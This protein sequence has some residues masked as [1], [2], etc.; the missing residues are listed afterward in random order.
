VTDGPVLTT[1]RLILRL[2]SPE[3]LDG[4]AEFAADAE[5]T[6]HLGGVKTRSEAWRYLCEMRGAWEIRG[7]AMFSVIERSTGRWAGR[8]GPWEPEGWPGTEVGWGVHPDFAGKGYAYEGAV[9]A[10]D[11]VV[12]VLGWSDICHTIAPD[13]IRS[14]ALAQRLGSTNRGPSRLPPP[15]Q[16]F[17]VDN[18][19]QSAEAWRSRRAALL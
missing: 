3:D 15:Y 10:M 6:R 14:I 16:D 9:A 5:T 18:W 19:G 4:F 7:F 11:Y 12:D 8:L 1:E 17:P 13:N 2:P